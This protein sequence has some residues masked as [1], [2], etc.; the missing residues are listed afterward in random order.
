MTIKKISILGSTGSIGKQTLDI[1]RSFPNH[2]EIQAL[3][4]HK[5]IELLKKQI[6]EFKP[7]FI[8]ITSETDKD[9]LSKWSEEQN[10]N[11]QFFSGKKGLNEISAIPTDLLVMAIVGTSGIAPTYTALKQKTPVAIACKEVLV[12]AGD[13]I[14]ALAHQHSTPIIPMDSEHAAIQQCIEGLSSPIHISNVSLTASGGPFWELNENEFKDITPESALKHPNW[15][16]GSK[17]SIDSA[18]MVNK[19]LEIIEAHHLFQLDYSK[20]NPIIHRQSIVHA[21]VE[22]IDGNILTHMSPTDMRF[23]IQYAL[24]YPE[25][26]NTPFQRL[27]LSSHTDLSFEEPNYKKFPL[28]KLAIEAGKQKGSHPVVFN[29]ANEA[30]VH[31][32]LN[33]KISFLDIQHRLEK[34]MNTYSHHPINSIDDI[35]DL[36]TKIKHD[37]LQPTI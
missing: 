33:K 36:D 21:I 19:G 3:T 17:I 30:L 35:I 7:L 14:M 28:L 5:N 12:S 34:I 24:S 29:A 16:M 15:N 23:P 2:F 8:S 10:L 13:I 37:L 26:L 6:L 22:Y 11:I 27:S 32:F 4:A 20:I 9:H 25:K 1:I 18:T 31:L